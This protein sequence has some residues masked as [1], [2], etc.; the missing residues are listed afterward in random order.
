MQ[1]IGEKI[2]N[3]I[4]KIFHAIFIVMY[5]DGSQYTRFLSYA[6]PER[7]IRNNRILSAISR[8]NHS[9]LRLSGSRRYHFWPFALVEDISGK[10]FMNPSA[11]T[12]R[13]LTYHRVRTQGVT[14]K[15]C[16]NGMYT[17]MIFKERERDL[18]AAFLVLRIK[19]I[20]SSP[21]SVYTN[22]W[23]VL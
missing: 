3:C 23:S 7:D 19:S 14:K 10:K 15:K 5:T 11:T 8:R 9:R 2:E 16:E 12:V 22:C 13:Y 18:E 21:A 20:I 1:S 6:T 4:L 17:R